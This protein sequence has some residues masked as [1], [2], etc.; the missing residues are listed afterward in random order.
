MHTII[1]T[2]EA[3]VQLDL[4]SG[5]IC[6]RTSESPDLS[7]QPFQTVAEIILFGH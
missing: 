7:L 4:E 5:T 3:S 6:R 1:H 2:I